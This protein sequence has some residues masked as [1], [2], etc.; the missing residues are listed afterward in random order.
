MIHVYLGYKY[1]KNPGNIRKYMPA[2]KRKAKQR[3]EKRE[4]E[5][6]KIK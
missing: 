3:K 5:K 2:K 1:K 6:E 4:G